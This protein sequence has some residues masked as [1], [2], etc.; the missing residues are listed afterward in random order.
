MYWNI[1]VR[2]PGEKRFAFLTPK[3]GRNHLKIH[4]VMIE[5]EERARKL[6]QEIMDLNK[7]VV[8]KVQ[9]V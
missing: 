8:A 1:K 4:A 2:G 6:A 9:P 3:Y 5:G 7:G